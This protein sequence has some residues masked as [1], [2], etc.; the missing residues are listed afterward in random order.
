MR[1]QLGWWWSRR[2]RR[3]WRRTRGCECREYSS[4]AR[5][6]AKPCQ[7]SLPRRSP[8]SSRLSN[9]IS[10][11][12]R[13]MDSFDKLVSGIVLGLIAVT[14]GVIA[15]GEH[16]SIQPEVEGD[17]RWQGTTLVVQPQSALESGQTYTVT[18]AAGV[19]NLAGRETISPTR[20]SFTPR[21]PSV[22]VLA[23]ADSAVRGLW[24][25]Q[26]EGGEPQALYAPEQDIYSFAA[27]P[28]GAVI[29]VSVGNAE[30]GADIRSEE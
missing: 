28:D 21:Q 12:E 22:L 20:W 19:A 3:V 1:R 30:Q 15:L 10:I 14:G 16:F 18:L 6:T 8:P 24:R 9:P 23:P 29:A 13:R 26:L 2:R 4:R 25:L 11:L 17:F 5:L 27:R 7:S